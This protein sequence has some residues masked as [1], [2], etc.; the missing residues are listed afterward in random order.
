MRREYCSIENSYP[1]APRSRNA[2]L[3]TLGVLSSRI[4]AF[5]PEEFAHVFYALAKFTSP[6]RE[7]LRDGS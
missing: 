1:P 5:T 3:S 6:L 4:L 7:I 2:R